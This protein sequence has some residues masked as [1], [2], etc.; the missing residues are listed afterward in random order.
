[1]KIQLVHKFEEIISLDNL[2]LA[3]REFIVGKKSKPDVQAFALDLF[4][5]IL[6]LHKS[7]SN[8]IY[9][10][11]A[12]GSFYIN[13]PKRRH[14]HK[15]SVADRLLHHAVCRILYPFFDKIFIS[16]S[17][18]CR[19]NKGTHKA[20]DRFRQFAAIE[21]K[22][23]THTCW[24]LKIDI[25]KF[26]ASIDHKI[27][28]EILEGYIYDADMLWLLAQIIKSF[29]SEGQNRKGLPLGNLTSQLFAN[30]YLNPFDQWIKHNLKVKFYIR[31]A[32][33]MVFLS[34]DKQA[35]IQILPEIRVF[36][37]E[38]LKL[39][40]HPD[41]II[42][43]TI[44]SGVDFLG[45]VYFIDHLILRKSTRW[46][47]FSRIKISPNSQTSQS[48]VGL[49]SHGNTYKLQRNLKNLFWIFN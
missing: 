36:M 16:D 5:N 12:Y 6:S 46:R 9:R 2:L 31:Y 17:Y 20:M 37:L 7:L 11:G 42:L 48:Y 39:N 43:K 1:M 45:W 33:D 13:D 8:K 30:I 3:W 24:V 41:K 10:H 23:H 27:L 21:S 25:R 32:D 38:N 4:G 18:S 14:I 26:F 29:N 35:L 49:L 19:L 47:M 34:A 40:L 22:N 28:L 15:A 44:A